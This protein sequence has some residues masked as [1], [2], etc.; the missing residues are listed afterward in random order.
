MQNKVTDR[1]MAAGLS[2]AAAYGP[3]CGP[4]FKGA[5]F[6]TKHKEFAW[7]SSFLRDMPAKPWTDFKAAP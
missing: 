4:E 1:T 6:V 2:F 3:Q 7:Q 5:E